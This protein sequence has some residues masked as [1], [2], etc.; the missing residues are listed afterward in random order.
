MTMNGNCF[1]SHGVNGVCFEPSLHFSPGGLFRVRNVKNRTMPHAGRS[2]VAVETTPLTPLTPCEADLFRGTRITALLRTAAAAAFLL[3]AGSGC[4][5]SARA[6][7]GRPSP[8]PDFLNE[9]G[10]RA[11]L[12]LLG[13]FHFAD[14]GQDAYRPRF[15]VD[16]ATAQR[17]REIESIVS[18]LARFRPTKV[19]V[20]WP[21]GDQL[22]LDS[23]YRAYRSGSDS[24][25]A[26]EVFQLGF[27]LAGRLGHE[28]VYAVDAEGRTPL[29]EAEARAQAAALGVNVDSVL[30]NDPWTAAYRRLYAY[31]DSLKTAMPLPD[32]LLRINEP[33]RIRRGHGDYLVGSF[34]LARGE[35]YV[36]VD[37]MTRWYNRNLRIFSLLQQ[38]TDSP[39]ER[40]AVIIGAGHLPILRFLAASSPEHRLVEVR[41]VLARP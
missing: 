6:P 7:G 34:K 35:N 33:E 41:D 24:L 31:E 27:R 14:P 3:A 1:A 4:A 39:E 15:R 8:E 25:G 28:R 40:I 20:E 18:R 11:Q 32:Y 9:A 37:D 17:Q 29:T 2:E 13:V 23:L 36:G 26:N 5:P 21:I 10:P 19:A 30:S 22:R 16:V 38:L 12:L